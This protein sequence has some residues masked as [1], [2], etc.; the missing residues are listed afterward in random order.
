MSN[1]AT[2]EDASGLASQIMAESSAELSAHGAPAAEKSEGETPTE[3]ETVETTTEAETP[4]EE[5]EPKS[6]VAPKAEEEPAKDPAEEGSV[7]TIKLGKTEFASPE[8]A[9]KEYNRVIG[10]SAQLAGKLSAAEAM[11]AAK[12]AEIQEAREANQMWVEWKRALDAGEDPTTTPAAAEI[13]K[14]L[15]AEEVAKI[16]KETIER[17]RVMA[18]HEAD[19]NELESLENYGEVVETIVRLAE[20]INPFTETYYTPKEAYAA[21]CQ[22]H[23]VQN[24]LVKSTAATPATPP[25]VMANPDA[26]KGAGRPAPAGAGGS[27]PKTEHVDA[28]EEHLQKQFA[29]L[30][31]I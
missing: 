15:S 6:E 16:T 7:R 3:N 2:G 22:H 27:A 17:D 10:H 12:D 13:P 4:A 30:E 26:V 21:A 29:R 25:R 28:S 18:R 20:K 5:T 31:M 14:G 9:S 23:G 1:V 11:I 24:L 19:I 8:E